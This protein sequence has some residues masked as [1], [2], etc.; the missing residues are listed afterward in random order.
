MNFYF[1][2]YEGSAEIDYEDLMDVLDFRLVSYWEMNQHPHYND[3]YL[4][5][6]FKRYVGLIMDSGAFTAWQ[7]GIIINPKAYIRYVLTEAFYIKYDYFVVLDE[8]PQDYKSVQ[9]CKDSAEA[10]LYNYEFMLEQFTKARADT[11]KIIPV[12]HQG[13]DPSYLEKYHPESVNSN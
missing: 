3:Y 9:S 4:G 10:S 6:Y 5:K 11:S 1:A 12:F 2:S 8:I 13:E 7:R